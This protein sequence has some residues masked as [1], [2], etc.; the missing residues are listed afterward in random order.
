[1][2]LFKTATPVPSKVCE[3][4]TL[5]IK[6]MTEDR[7]DDLRL[8]ISVPLSKLQLR[9][10]ELRSLEGR[11]DPEGAARRNELLSECAQIENSELVAL[12][13]AWGVKGITGLCIDSEENLATVEE[14]R[15]WPSELVAEVID[16]V[17]RASGLS[18]EETKNSESRTTPS[19]QDSVETSD[20][21]ALSAS[22]SESTAPETAGS[23]TQ[24]T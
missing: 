22:A 12:K 9:S 14:W 4:V 6:K 19:A 23:S 13:M 3:G 8:K 16:M 24:T 5:T 18:T 1:M 20:T 11:K 7:R 2:Y 15:K 21:T 10:E 17:D